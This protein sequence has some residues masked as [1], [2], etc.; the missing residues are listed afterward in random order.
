MFCKGTASEL[1][2][3]P[4]VSTSVA[5][6]WPLKFS[7]CFI[8][9][10]KLLYKFKK[11]AWEISSQYNANLLNLQRAWNIISL[12]YEYWRDYT[13][14]NGR[15]RGY[16][17]VFQHFFTDCCNIQDISIPVSKHRIFLPQIFH[18]SSGEELNPV[19]T[20]MRTPSP[21]SKLYCQLCCQVLW[22]IAPVHWWVKSRQSWVRVLLPNKFIQW[23]SYYVESASDLESA[24]S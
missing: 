3:V 1:K 18:Y 4:G 24:L 20:K 7:F 23:T 17:T 16:L 6:E 12:R 13:R 10:K 2:S 8:K 5:E 15:T 22:G 9:K 19:L 11:V 21:L 14:S